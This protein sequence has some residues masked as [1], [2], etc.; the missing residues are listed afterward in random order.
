MALGAGPV[1]VQEETT[2]GFFVNGLA[3][4]AAQAVAQQLV[5]S[6]GVVQFGEEQRLAVVGPG[7]AAVALLERQL[8]D[9]TAGQFLDI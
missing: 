4:F 1:A 9:G 7:H 3:T 2:I 6:M 5:R 8:L